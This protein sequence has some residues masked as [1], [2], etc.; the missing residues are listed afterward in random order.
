MLFCAMWSVIWF[1][2]SSSIFPVPDCITAVL[3]VDGMWRC[4]V[5]GMGIVSESSCHDALLIAFVIVS[6]YVLTI[7]VGV[8]VGFIT[9]WVRGCGQNVMAIIGRL[10][11]S[12][13]NK[14]IAHRLF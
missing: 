7:A 13:P 9:D 8:D 14:K 5:V 11:R 6:V 10:I 1:G 12:T 2:N 3:L 4:P